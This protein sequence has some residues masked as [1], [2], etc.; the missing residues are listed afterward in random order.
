MNEYPLRKH[1]VLYCKDGQTVVLEN[2][3][4]AFVWVSYKGK[5]YRRPIEALNKTL[6]FNDPIQ[7]K[8]HIDEEIDYEEKS[9]LESPCSK[10]D[11]LTKNKKTA[12]STDEEKTERT[13]MNCKI[14][15]SGECFSARLCK[16]YEPAYTVP[17]SERNQWPEYGAA[18]MLK[19]RN[20]KN[21]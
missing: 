7:R 6:F 4:Y 11:K 8:K 1:M 15:R 21:N 12:V 3:S 16:D 14:Q 20:Y 19:R 9:I 10:K 18:T 2:Y 17:E 13:C 5:I